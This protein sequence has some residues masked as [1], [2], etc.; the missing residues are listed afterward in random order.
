MALSKEETLEGNKLIAEY[1]GWRFDISNGVVHAYFN[2]NKR[3]ANNEKFLNSMLESPEAFGFHDNWEN[4]MVTAEKICNTKIEGIPPF[5]S[6]QYVRME[7]VPNGYVKIENLRDTPI[8]T[9]VSVEGSLIAA[10]WKA[11]VK[12]LKWYNS[13]KQ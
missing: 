10:V 4:L 9:N 2:G 1:Y 11:E 12:F 3:W 8:F 6:D 7:I 13:Q 5:N